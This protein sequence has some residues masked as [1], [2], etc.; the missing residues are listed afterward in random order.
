MDAEAGHITG[1]A[2]WPWVEKY[3]PGFLQAKAED[4]QIRSMGGWTA[5][6]FGRPD[7]DWIKSLR[8][9]R[10]TP[11]RKPKEP[12]M[13]VKFKRDRDWTPPEDRRLTVSYKQGMELTVKRSW[14]EAMVADG[15][16]EEIEPPA[17]D[18]LDHD[19]DGRKGGSKRSVHA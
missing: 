11:R 5:D 17:R 4:V 8:L 10:A 12:E 9:A 15:D 13:R 14:G 16:A 3:R 2:V 1:L 7:A 6:V 19:G 18:P